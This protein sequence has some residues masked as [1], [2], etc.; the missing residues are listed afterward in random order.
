MEDWDLEVKET[1]GIMNYLKN[2]DQDYNHEADYDHEIGDKIS[3]IKNYSENYSK[4]YQRCYDHEADYDQ[5][6]ILP[7][8]NY[9][10]DY[11]KGYDHEEDID[12]ENQCV[13]IDYEQKN[14]KNSPDYYYFSS[15]RGFINDS[16]YPEKCPDDGDYSDD[17]YYHEEYDD[18]MPVR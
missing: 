6:K 18:S 10:K 1:S 13:I 12:H 15:N 14:H 9:S 17:A 8:E 16:T 3:I 7:A 11:Q 4:D 2:Y 5:Y